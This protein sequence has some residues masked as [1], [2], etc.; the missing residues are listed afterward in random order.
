M[1]SGANAFRAAPTPE[2]HTYRRATRMTSSQ[3]G[4][5]GLI[6]SAR[7]AGEKRAVPPADSGMIAHAGPGW[8]VSGGRHS[9]HY[10]SKQGAFAIMMG[11]PVVRGNPELARLAHDRGIAGACAEQYRRQGPA[12]LAHLDGPFA[13]AIHSADASRTLLAVDKLGVASMYYRADSEAFAFASDLAAMHMAGLPI[14]TVDEQAIFDYLFFH[15]IPGPKTIFKEVRRVPSGGC[16]ERDGTGHRVSKYWQLKYEHELDRIDFETAKKEMLTL[17][18]SSVRPALASGK[19]IGCFL[20]G[21]TDSSTLAGILTEVG[22]TPAC[23]Y[24][25]GFDQRGFDEI[26]YARIAARHFRTDHHEY[27]VQPKDIVRVAGRLAGIYGQPFG[28]S[29]V[30]PTK[31]CADVAK[32]DGVELMIGGDGGDELFGGNSRY[33]TQALFSYYLQLPGPLR[34]YFIEPVIVRSPLARR[35]PPVRKVARYVEQ[36]LIPMPD[37]LQTYNYLS[38]LGSEAIFEHEFLARID[39]QV[40]AREFAAEYDAQLS[41]TMLNKML[42]L[43]L[44]F[45]LSD[46]DIPKVHNMCRA[47]GVDV[48]FPFL[49][50]QIV[51][52]AA[53][54][55]VDQKVRRLKLRYFF[56]RALS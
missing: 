13:L 22:Q 8:A 41:G 37:R 2:L 12:F 48:M 4:I 9:A 24:S 44:K 40:P 39:Q 14:A 7:V 19:K 34:R 5:R 29:A 46:N 16:V 3:S 18:R 10:W 42:G 30:V 43:D 47:S 20:S 26:E 38:M 6:S 49:D 15:M 25:I 36:A 56:K 27:Y 35:I 32:A 31:C 33:A 21:G 45:T 54:L 28:N 1:G 50:Q 55:P 17:L 52:F 51:E 23:T 11:A 53:R